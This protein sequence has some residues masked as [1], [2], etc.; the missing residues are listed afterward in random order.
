MAH[1]PPAW[2]DINSVTLRGR[3]GRDA[4]MRSTNGGMQIV[5]L[6]VATG[7]SWTDKRTGERRSV[8]QWHR[9][10]VKFN[11]VA[12]NAAC[13]LRK[14]DRVLLKGKVTYR[15]WEQ[16]GVKRFA[17]EIE[18]GRFGEIAL[19]PDD[20]EPEKQSR[21]AAKPAQRRAAPSTD[22][23]LSDDIPF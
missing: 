6:S 17:T 14:G 13:D 11:D 21:P 22:Y 19:V 10:V 15:E 12:V 18:V 1:E 5:N 2:A 16:E 9:V 20:R 8:T 7:E 4:E 3:L 23:D